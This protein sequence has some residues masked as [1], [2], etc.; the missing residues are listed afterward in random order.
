MNY[1]LNL[2]QEWGDNWLQP[3]QDRLNKAYPNLTQDELNNYNAIAQEAMK[4]GYNL[5]YSMVEQQGIHIDD[6]QWKIEYSSRFP[7]VDKQ[8][9]SHLFSTGKYYAWKDGIGGKN[10]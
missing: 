7:W 1:A 3:I 10:A 9:L 6:V 2:A 5:V 4:F 8:N